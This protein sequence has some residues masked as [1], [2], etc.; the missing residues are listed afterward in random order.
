[1]LVVIFLLF[2]FIL[3]RPQTKRNKEY[4]ELINK[5]KKGDE[6]VTSGGM[7][8]KVT[9]VDEQYIKIIIAE[10]IEIP[11]QKTAVSAVLPK[12]SLKS[13]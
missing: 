7:L 10:G 4:R 6:V 3:I 11:L 13:I 9:S 12:G 2:Y 8:G 5:V 1:M